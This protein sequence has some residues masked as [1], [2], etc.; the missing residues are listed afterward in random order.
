MQY[1][2]RR[3][4]ESKIVF[5]GEGAEEVMT[6]Y[7]PVRVCA[8][9]MDVDTDG[10]TVKDV[11][12][13]G[14]CPGQANALPALVKGMKIDEAISRLRGIRCRSGT[15]CADQLGRILE[16]ERDEHRAKKVILL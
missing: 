11:R 3:Q 5:R 10:E 14:G 6:R 7:R 8:R 4:V 15:S 16:Q 12:I 13:Y 2:L 1:R 9:A